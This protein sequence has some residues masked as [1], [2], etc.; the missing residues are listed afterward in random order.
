MKYSFKQLTKQSASKKEIIR[1]KATESKTEYQ[2]KEITKHT[3]TLDRKVNGWI[4]WGS[5]SGP[6]HKIPQNTIARLG[7][8]N[9]LLFICQKI[10]LQ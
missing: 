9:N 4:L 6:S 3:Y 10:K 8:Q 1:G 2:H 5:G 7:T